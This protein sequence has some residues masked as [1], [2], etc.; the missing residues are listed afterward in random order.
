M[1]PWKP[2]IERL[3]GAWL[4]RVRERKIT[5]C[6]PRRELTARSFQVE[7]VPGHCAVRIGS[8]VI[9]ARDTHRVR[10]R[11]SARDESSREHH[12]NSHYV[13]LRTT[14]PIVQSPPFHARVSAAKLISSS[15]NCYFN[16]IRL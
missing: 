3:V 16:V 4:V 9:R 7:L 2:E 11:R 8:R 10:H 15:P 6:D 12:R 14:D 5:E 13:N 1:D